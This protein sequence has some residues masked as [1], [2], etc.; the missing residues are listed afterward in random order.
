MTDT[1]K[2]SALPTPRSDFILKASDALAG[3]KDVTPFAAQSLG[4]KGLTMKLKQLHDL[5]QRQTGLSQV[6]TEHFLELELLRSTPAIIELYEAA[7]DA[8]GKCYNMESEWEAAI[9]S[10]ERLESALKVLEQ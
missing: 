4:E 2:A 1:E 3:V 6:N 9:R 8:V 10:L 7:K 5:H